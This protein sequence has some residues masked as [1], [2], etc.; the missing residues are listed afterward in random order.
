M[1]EENTAGKRIGDVSRYPNNRNPAVPTQWDLRKVMERVT[2][3]QAEWSRE[4]IVTAEIDYR[5]YLQ[6]RSV[7]PDGKFSPPPDVRVVWQTHMLF[8]KDYAD[9]CND[10]F[11]HFLSFEF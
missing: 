7:A 5:H 6:L 11:G 4:R 9:F 1:L 10:Y 2:E 3:E 8:S